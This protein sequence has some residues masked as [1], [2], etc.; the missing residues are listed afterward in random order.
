MRFLPR[1]LAINDEPDNHQKI[2]K[3]KKKRRRKRREREHKETLRNPIRKLIEAES[4]IKEIRRRRPRLLSGLCRARNRRKEKNRDVNREKW[5][6]GRNGMQWQV[7][8]ASGR[9]SNKSQL[10][11]LMNT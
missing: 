2:E 1:A 9:V 5:Q 6:K 4:L 10:N 11:E 7:G 3:T 8:E